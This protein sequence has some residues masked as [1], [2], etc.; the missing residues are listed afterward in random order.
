MIVFSQCTYS[1]LYEESYLLSFWLASFTHWGI[2]KVSYLSCPTLY[3]VL[4]EHKLRI[5]MCINGIPYSSTLSPTF[6]IF[7][8]FRK[9]CIFIVLLYTSYMRTETPSVEKEFSSYHNLDLKDKNYNKNASYEKVIIG[10][11]CK[12]NKICKRRMLGNFYE[13]VLVFHIFLRFT[14]HERSHIL[15]ASTYF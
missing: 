1:C 14:K 2:Q 10:L 6:N 8:T 7:P 9:L 3:S 5:C 11:H 4:N 12:D 13:R 15:K